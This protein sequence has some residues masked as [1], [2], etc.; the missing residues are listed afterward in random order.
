MKKNKYLC[1]ILALGATMASCTS[2]GTSVGVSAGPAYGGYYGWDGEWIPTI[3]HAPL[4]SPYYY[5]GAAY[6]ITHWQ[7]VPRPGTGP[8]GTPVK[9]P[10]APIIPSRPNSS[11]GNVRP[12]QPSASDNSVVP[13]RPINLGTTPGIQLPPEGMGYRVNTSLR[14]KQ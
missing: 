7:P 9:P 4:I 2:L 11:A 14:P 1:L 3:A 6:P 8:L 13:D 12:G 10:L 5:G